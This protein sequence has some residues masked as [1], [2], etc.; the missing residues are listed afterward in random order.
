[1]VVGGLMF[2][3]SAFKA[4]VLW[5]KGVILFIFG[6]LLNLSITFLPLPDIFQTI[7]SS[8]RNLGLIGIGFGLMRTQDKSLPIS[9]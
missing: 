2:G 5:R 3:F 4:G 6:L 7:G 1:M 9:N 8:I